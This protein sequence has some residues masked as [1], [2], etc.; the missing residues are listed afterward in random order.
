[1][2][3]V[4]GTHSP[5]TIELWDRLLAY[6]AA[7]GVARGAS[8]PLPLRAEQDTVAWSNEGGRWREITISYPR[9]WPLGWGAEPG[10]AL[11]V[12]LVTAGFAGY[13]LY[14]SGVEQLDAGPSGWLVLLGACVAVV[15]GVAVVVV[16]ASDWATAIEVTGA[17]PSTPC[18]RRG[19]QA[20]LLR[21]RG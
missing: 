12:G 8:W 19:R 20:A 15:V 3:S 17:D 13:W 1:M 18:D 11:A 6:G 16:A 2:N 10:S 5:L 9:L 21:G 4:F 7:L 14:K